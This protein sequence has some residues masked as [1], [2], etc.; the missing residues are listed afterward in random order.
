VPSRVARPPRISSPLKNG[1][2]ATLRR[3]GLRAALLAPLVFAILH[4][5]YGLGSLKGLVSF[6]LLRRGLSQGQE[7]YQMSR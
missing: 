4:S 6:V 2:F 3:C 7:E 5:E 1:G